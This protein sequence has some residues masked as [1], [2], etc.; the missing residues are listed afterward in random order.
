M[1]PQSASRRAP[2]RPLTVFHWPDHPGGGF[3]TVAEAAPV[4][5]GLTVAPPV[6][7]VERVA[8]APPTRVGSGPLDQGEVA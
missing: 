8:P 7:Q 2:A 3:D 1:H 4:A 5:P 6:H